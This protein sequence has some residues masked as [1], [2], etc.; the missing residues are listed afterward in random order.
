MGIKTYYVSSNAIKCEKP[1]VAI[2]LQ[3]GLLLNFT[4]SLHIKV[5]A[6]ISTIPK[7][8]TLLRFSQEVKI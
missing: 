4:K 6:I 5:E 2:F 8:V 7:L 1:Q 3:R